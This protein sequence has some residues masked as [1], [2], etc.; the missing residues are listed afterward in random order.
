[1][2]EPPLALKFYLCILHSASLLSERTLAGLARARKAGRVGGRP[3]V[4]VNRDKVLH[5]RR[6]GV[7]LSQ[8]ADEFNISKG[9]VYNIVKA[10]SA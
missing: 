9:S 10:A 4:V 2:V 1:M 6:Q 7:S 8:I 3:K 5:R